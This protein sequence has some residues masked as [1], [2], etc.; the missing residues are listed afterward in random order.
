VPNCFERIAD[1]VPTCAAF[2]APGLASVQQ[3]LD[4]LSGAP[5]RRAR[6]EIGTRGNPGSRRQSKR[7]SAPTYE[8][9]RRLITC[10]AAADA[11][12]E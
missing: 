2:V 6:L 9:S 8:S 4:A 11:I 1:D 3:A 12:T 10:R 5:W 7:A